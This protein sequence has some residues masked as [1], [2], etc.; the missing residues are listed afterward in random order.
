MITW[1][2]NMSVG[3]MM[4]DQQHKRLVEMVNTIYQAISQGKGDEVMNDT[5]SGLITYTKNHF[6]QEEKF[7]QQIGFPGLAAHQKIHQDLT[8]KAQDIADQI[9]AGKRVSSVTVA[10]FLKQWLTDHIMKEDMKYAAHNRA[11]VS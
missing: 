7:M 9:K 11:S 4:I 1:S 3:N 10:N 2:D 5:L 6:I 8:A